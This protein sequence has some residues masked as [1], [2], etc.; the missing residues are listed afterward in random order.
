MRGREK[1][2]KKGRKSKQSNKYGFCLTYQVYCTHLIGFVP[3][4]ASG[5]I[6][7]TNIGL[8]NF[9]FGFFYCWKLHKETK[10]V[11]QETFFF[12]KFTFIKA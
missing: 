12:A 9:G 4:A 10:E 6:N 11:G 7:K 2:E 3:N 8:V 5:D 1:E